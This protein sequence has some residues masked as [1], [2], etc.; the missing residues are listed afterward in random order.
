MDKTSGA[1][2]Q[3][4]SAAVSNLERMLDSLPNF[5]K[6]LNS[7]VASAGIQGPPPAQISGSRKATLLGNLL[8]AG[9]NLTT[10]NALGAWAAL[11]SE[12]H[13]EGHIERRELEAVIKEITSINDHAA[14][15]RP[16]R[17]TWNALGF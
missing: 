7:V 2:F 16:S 3:V 10:D 17:P 11:L 5:E 1:R 8:R 9:Q 15:R 6:S 14:K 13:T 4:A 12:A